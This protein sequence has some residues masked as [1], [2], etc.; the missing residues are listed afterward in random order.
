MKIT[1]RISCDHSKT[2]FLYMKKKETRKYADLSN[3]E[4]DEMKAYFS[5]ETEFEQWKQ[6]QN[7]LFDS[8]HVPVSMQT[9]KE[10]KQKLDHLFYKTHQKKSI[11]WMNSFFVLPDKKWYSQPAMGIAAVLLVGIFTVPLL[12]L[13]QAKKQQLAKT[14]LKSENKKSELSSTS[15]QNK[16]TDLNEN[17]K[18]TESKISISKTV[19][20]KS[21]EE[22][23]QLANLE[24]SF[25]EEYTFSR[26]SEKT[27]QD[28]EIFSDF[29]SLDSDQIQSTSINLNNG[30]VETIE[31]SQFF[32][33]ISS[34]F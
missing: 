9:R 19:D 4:K 10:T 33:V 31:I 2:N 1:R 25:P 8:F 30:N 28:N 22:P 32:D 21:L 7:N 16:F 34:T 18:T 27:I 3:R 26:S 24:E 13:N 11:F 17:K 12:F 5:N 15:K 6:F 29:I 20:P 23:I 14:E